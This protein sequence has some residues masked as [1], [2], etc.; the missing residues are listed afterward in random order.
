MKVIII[1]D[2]KERIEIPDEDIRDK[3]MVIDDCGKNITLLQENEY[4]LITTPDE[5]D[6]PVFK[7]LYEQIPYIIVSHSA[8]FEEAKF[9][10]ERG[11]ISYIEGS[12]L[13]NKGF[14]LNTVNKAFKKCPSYIERT[15]L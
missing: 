8:S 9:F 3:S 5:I 4:I 2:S 14:F 15:K 6:S 7:S 1:L 12:V 13:C 11:A 10:M